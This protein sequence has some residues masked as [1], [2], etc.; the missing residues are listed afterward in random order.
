VIP[1]EG[2]SGSGGGGGGAAGI[3]QQTA[4]EFEL[5]R[6][7]QQDFEL[8]IKNKFSSTLKN[9]KIV[10]SG[11]NA[12]YLEVIPS[13]IEQIGPFGSEN[14]T[15]RILAPAYFSKGEYTLNF[16]IS[17]DSFFNKTKRSYDENLIVVLNVIEVSREEVDEMISTSE[18]LIEELGKNGVSAEIVDLRTVS[19]LDMETITKSVEK[20]GREVIVQEAQLQAGVADKVASEISQRSILSLEE[21]IKVVAA[22]DTVFPFG[23]AENA[24]LP[25]ATDI[26]AAANEIT[27]K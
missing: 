12:K 16:K 11:I 22:P 2:S 1:G 26:V 23:M 27:G 3:S 21:P 10:S 5:V 9:L 24:W 7:K 6:G 25:N 14:I 17:G 18:N 20:T 8:E 13:E 4:A 19:P 15:V